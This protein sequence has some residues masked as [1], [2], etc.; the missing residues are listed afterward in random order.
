MV[1]VFLAIDFPC[2]FRLFALFW[3]CC[4]ESRR[5]GLSACVVIPLIG[6]HFQL[7]SHREKSTQE[8]FFFSPLPS[9]VLALFLVELLSR[10]RGMYRNSRRSINTFRTIVFLLFDECMHTPDKPKGDYVSCCS[11]VCRESW[12]GK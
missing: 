1:C 8:F 4:L 3:Y 10:E 7:G 2:T 9:A 11:M 5:E 12:G 6:R